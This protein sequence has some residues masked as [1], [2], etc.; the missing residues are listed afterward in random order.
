MP[1]PVPRVMYRPH[2]GVL[3]NLSILASPAI[4]ASFAMNIGILGNIGKVAHGWVDFSSRG[5]GTTLLRHL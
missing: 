2:L 4:L 5:F 1:T 3:G